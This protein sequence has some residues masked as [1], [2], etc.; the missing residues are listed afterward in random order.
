M[1]LYRNVKL[2]IATQPPTRAEEQSR[3]ADAKKRQMALFFFAM[4][5]WALNGKKERTGE[6]SGEEKRSEKRRG[7]WR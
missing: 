4:C 2:Q 1:T 5:M 3:Q 6:K 7:K